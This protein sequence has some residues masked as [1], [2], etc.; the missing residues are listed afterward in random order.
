MRRVTSEALRTG[1]GSV[2]NGIGQGWTPQCCCETATESFRKAHV[3]AKANQLTAL[4]PA[5]AAASS[6]AHPLPCQYG[7]SSRYLKPDTSHIARTAGT[8]CSHHHGE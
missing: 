4:R 7:A 6:I 8:V 1:H 3:V 5:G 2:P